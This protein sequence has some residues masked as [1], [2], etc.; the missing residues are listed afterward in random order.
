MAKAMVP[1]FVLRMDLRRTIFRLVEEDAQLLAEYC[2]LAR[3]ETLTDREVLDACLARNPPIVLVSVDGEQKSHW[4]NIDTL[5]KGP[6][7]VDYQEMRI[8][9]THYLGDMAVV[10]RKV[11][12]Q[13]QKEHPG[14]TNLE[15]S[16]IAKERV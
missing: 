10:G 1:T 4:D 13:V 6:E 11:A 8:N 15:L 5:Q 16:E 2:D 14:K 12:E 7:M 9:L 3:C